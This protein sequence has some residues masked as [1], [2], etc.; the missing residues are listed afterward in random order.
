MAAARTVPTRYAVYLGRFESQPLVFAHL[1]DA[2][3]PLD[4]D[5]VQVICNTD[6]RA[7]LAHAFAPETA[8][9]VEDAM[10][11]A[12]TC[13]L[14]PV[15]AVT[16]DTRLPEATDRLTWLGTHAGLRHVPGAGD[17]PGDDTA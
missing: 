13:V 5:E 4:L 10:G 11:L 8:E 7:R 6:P 12:T 9:A 3:P 14:I 15:E 2:F 16:G 17:G 1:L